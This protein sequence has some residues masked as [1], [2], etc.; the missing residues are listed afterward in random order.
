MYFTILHSNTQAHHL[1]S[2]PCL[3]RHH[4]GYYSNG[5]VLIF[6]NNDTWNNPSCCF[7]LSAPTTEGREVSA[8]GPLPA[9]GLTFWMLGG[10]MP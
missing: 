1:Q 10:D 6:L 9:Q 4:V 8:H 2:Q 3:K 7:W 5:N